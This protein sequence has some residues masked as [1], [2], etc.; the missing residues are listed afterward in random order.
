LIAQKLSVIQPSKNSRYIDSGIISLALE[1]QQFSILQSYEGGLEM[2]EKNLTN[3]GESMTACEELSLLTDR[4]WSVI[5]GEACRVLEFIP[6]GCI[7]EGRI[8]AGMTGPYASI[9]LECKNIQGTITGYITH[10]IDF[11]HLWEVFE[12][13]TIQENEEVII[14]WTKQHYKIKS[15]RYFRGFPKLWVLVHR[16][17]YLDFNADP[18]HWQPES[19]KRP[20]TFEMLTP[21]VSL[22]WEGME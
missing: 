11:R 5:D 18:K 6:Y 10:R 20:S 14:I 4:E 22:K 1:K 9:I 16:K 21:I 7:T 3:A 17:G 12:E 8:I 2:K 15:L 19:G 13:R